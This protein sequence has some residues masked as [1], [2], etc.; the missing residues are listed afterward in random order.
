MDH[1]RHAAFHVGN[2]VRLGHRAPGPDA[3]PEAIGVM[4]PNMNIAVPDRV[5][6]PRATSTSSCGENPCEKP[7]SNSTFTIPIALGVA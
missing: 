6:E 1:H 4:D 3:K 7:I 2:I 5:L